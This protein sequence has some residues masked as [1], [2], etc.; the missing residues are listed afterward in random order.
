[1]CEHYKKNYNVSF[2]ENSLKNEDKEKIWSHLKESF[3]NILFKENK[4]EESYICC[5]PTKNLKVV[6]VGGKGGMAQFFIRYFQKSSYDIHILDKDDWDKSSSI[7]KNAFLVII[8]V[9]IDKTL[10]VIKEVSKNIDR[11]TIL[12]DLTSVKT[13]VVNCLLEYHNGP[14]ISLHPMFGPDTFSFKNQ[15]VVYVKVKEDDKCKFLYNQLVSYGARVCINTA[16]EHD[17]AMAIIQA[18]RHFTT[19]CYGIFLSSTKSNL[20]HILQLSSPIYH[21]ELLMVGRLFAQDPYLYGDIIMSN[22]NNLELIEKYCKSLKDDLDLIL[23][24][25]IDTFVHKFKEASDYFG[26]YGK[27]FL[28]DSQLVLESFQKIRK[29]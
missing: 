14:S 6:F 20:K 15:V 28:Q 17:E 1:M 10:D 12:C 26:D 27:Q 7:L 19:Y 21:L 5:A 9:P 25:D 23:R 3:D 18:L 4:K 11:D 22:S 8:S 13:N 29:K 24:K 2:D 16:K